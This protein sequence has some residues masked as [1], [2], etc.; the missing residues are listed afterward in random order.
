MNVPIVF[1]HFF[2][3]WQLSC[4][5]LKNCLWIPCRLHCGSS[6]CLA[7]SALLFSFRILSASVCYFY[8]SDD[9][10]SLLPQP[11]SLSVCLHPLVVNVMGRKW[12]GV[13]DW[14]GSACRVSSA[15]Q[16]WK[17]CSGIGSVDVFLCCSLLC[18]FILVWGVAVYMLVHMQW[19]CGFAPI[20]AAGEELRS[21][22][23][24]NNSK[25]ENKLLYYR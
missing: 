25:V 14:L 24:I 3:V 17:S 2:M 8:V 21:L 19:Y 12:R 18:L 11:S 23:K 6:P 10:S 9:L 5:E 1:I 20:T 13:T 7:G 15:S 4:R 16:F 22:S